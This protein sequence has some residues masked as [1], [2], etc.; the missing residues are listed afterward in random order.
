MKVTVQNRYCMNIDNYNL[1]LLLLLPLCNPKIT[2]ADD[3]LNGYEGA[4]IDGFS[5]DVNKPY[6]QECVHLVFETSKYI[7]MKVDT[8]IGLDETEYISHYRLAG[9]WVESYALKIDSDYQSEY[10]LICENKLEMLPMT[11]KLRILKFWDAKVSTKLYS[12]LM[13]LAPVMENVSKEV[14][15]EEDY[16]E[17]ECPS[18]VAFHLRAW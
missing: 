4:L 13:G 12:A 2:K 5:S 17:D 16:V 14:V 18:N 3:Y 1:A 10:A 11:T 6:I 15:M 9:I 7:S 8:L